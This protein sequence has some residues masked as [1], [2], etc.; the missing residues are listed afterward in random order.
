[1]DGITPAKKKLISYIKTYHTEVKDSD[2]PLLLN[3]IQRFVSVIHKIY[4]EPQAKISF[5]EVKENGIKVKKRFV[6][7]NIEELMKVKR[8]AGEPITT[9]TIRELTEKVLGVKYK[10]HGE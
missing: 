1:M 4:T 3:N 6:E 5:K 7:T 2:L 9:K 10:K 8:D